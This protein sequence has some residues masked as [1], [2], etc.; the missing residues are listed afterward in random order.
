MKKLPISVYIVASNEEER[1]PTTLESVMPF[2]DEVF[3]ILDEKSKDNTQ[4]I[5][6]SYGA[7]VIV[8]D[9]KGF[10]MQKAFG[11]KQCK[12]DWVLDLDADEEVSVELQ[13]KLQELFGGETLPDEGGFMMTW[14]VL[15]PGQQKAAKHAHTDYIIRLYNRKKATINEVE[16]SNHDRPKVHTGKISKIKEPV[17]H[18]TILSLS[19]LE[20]KMTLLTR[21]QAIHNFNKGKK[22]SS[23]KFYTDFQLKF[24]KYFIL[25]KMFLHGWY[26]YT[27][28][29]MAAYRNFMRLAKTRELYLVEEQKKSNMTK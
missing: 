3:V 14:K 23:F 9:W 25:R 24:W 16:F 29:I 11:A 13:A 26:G 6:E 19:H 18:R 28:A 12:N 2:A 20:G 7:K 8:N 22:I 5:A 17:Y 21:E 15:Y 10:A 27:L 1:I 4:K